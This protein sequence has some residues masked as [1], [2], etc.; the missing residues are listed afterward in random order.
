M[1]AS[2]KIINKLF[3]KKIGFKI[4]VV[5]TFFLSLFLFVQMCTNYHNP[6]NSYVG[7]KYDNFVIFVDENFRS[8]IVHHTIVDYHTNLCLDEFVKQAI[9]KGIVSI[10]NFDK[11]RYSY[12]YDLTERVLACDKDKLQNFHSQYQMVNGRNFTPWTVW[13]DMKIVVNCKKALTVSLMPE[14]DMSYFFKHDFWICIAFSFM[15]VP[16]VI[17]ILWLALRFII[18]SPILWIFHKD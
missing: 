12:K 8:D 13:T 6:Y 1:V 3:F 2:D 16:L 17:F 11:Y 5:L 10:E 9:N 14:N 7:R 15:G 4:F 18:I